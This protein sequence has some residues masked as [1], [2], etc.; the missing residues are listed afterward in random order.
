MFF[1]LLFFS[2]TFHFYWEQPN[3]KHIK[4]YS[5]H[6]TFS[7]CMCHLQTAVQSKFNSKKF[8]I[9]WIVFILFKH[10]IE[11]QW[12]ENGV[13]CKMLQLLTFNYENW[14]HKFLRYY[15]HSCTKCIRPKMSRLKNE[16]LHLIISK[17][18]HLKRMA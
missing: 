2:F 4:L 3:F 15:F 13:A 6:S 8:L 11:F 7:I 10:L 1:S 14:C 9:P 5:S 16:F 18:T 17:S 12:C